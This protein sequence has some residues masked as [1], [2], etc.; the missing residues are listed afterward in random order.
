[1]NKCKSVSSKSLTMLLMCCLLLVAGCS[2]SPRANFYTLTAMAPPATA[3]PQRQAPSLAVDA[4]TLPEVVDRPQFVIVE[5]NNRV[6]ILEMQQWA[7]SLKNAIPRILADNLSRQLGL[8]RVAAYPQHAGST[9]DYR[10]AVDFQRFEA[11]A[12]S[13]ELDAIWTV[14]ST[15]SAPLTGRSRVH[16]AHGGYDSVAAAY[17][18]A[19]ATVSGDIARAMPKELRQ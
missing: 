6:E 13:V 7:E 19:L 12:R 5:G 14:R 1:M 4:V 3:A 18:R 15:G 11:T 2:R 17:S 9:A 10:L 16:E 8:E